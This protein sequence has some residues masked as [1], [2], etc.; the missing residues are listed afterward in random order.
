MFDKVLSMP[1][2]LNV[3]GFWIAQGS[4]SVFVSECARILDI[5]GSEYVSGF[6]RVTQGLEYGWIIPEYALLC[7]NMS[8]YP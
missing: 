1:L 4:E 5:P 6:A 8:E 2:V 3:P 7:L